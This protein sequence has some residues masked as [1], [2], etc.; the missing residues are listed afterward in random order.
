MLVHV[1]VTQPHWIN[2]WSTAWFWRS[3]RLCRT[4]WSSD[5]NLMKIMIAKFRRKR[6]RNLYC[7][8][9][10]YTKFESR[11]DAGLTLVGRVIY[12]TPFRRHNLLCDKVFWCTMIDIFCGLKCCNRSSNLKFI[13]YIVHHCGPFRSSMWRKCRQRDIYVSV[14]EWFCLSFFIPPPPL[15][16]S[17]SSI[18]CLFT[19]SFLALSQAVNVSSWYPYLSPMCRS[20]P[21]YP[22]TLLWISPLNTPPQKRQYSDENKNIFAV[23]TVCF[24]VFRKLVVF[25][26]IAIPPYSMD[27]N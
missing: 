9:R 18:L 23:S 25:T 27:R 1:G 20:I 7:A 3:S 8:C 6:V 17:L 24:L 2:N 26:S 22:V 13:I 16:L 10:P 15:S 14:M 11:A 5:R 19:L 21:R 12:K 4:T